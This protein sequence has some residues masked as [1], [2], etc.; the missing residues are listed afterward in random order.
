MEDL[1]Y[2]LN[3]TTNLNKHQESD[4]EVLRSVSGTTSKWVDDVIHEF[5]NEGLLKNPE[6][7]K[8]FASPELQESSLKG[9][10]WYFGELLAGNKPANFWEHM[11]TVG[12]IHIYRGVKI[13][14]V[15][16]ITARVQE[17]VLVKAFQSF[18]PNQALEVFTAFHRI[19]STT[20]TILVKSY[21]IGLLTGL[22]KVGMNESLIDRVKTTA[23][24][25]MIEEMRGQA[26][27]A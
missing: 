20:A 13:A 22:T 23:V 27:S 12:M 19:S 24:R 3:V 21:Q 5:L 2:V 18:P 15:L 9:L 26:A 17:L 4:W 6:T 25:K 16:G 1:K 14:F 7:A 11:W 10:R 8:V